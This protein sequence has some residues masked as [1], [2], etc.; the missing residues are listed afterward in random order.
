MVKIAINIFLSTLLLVESLVPRTE[1]LEIIQLPELFTHFKK[2]KQERPAMTILEF[3]S[4]HYNDARHYASDFKN[5]QKLPFSKNHHNH[6]IS[7]Q[8][9][10]QINTPYF[11]LE[12]TLLRLIDSVYYIEPTTSLHSNTVWQPP[13]VS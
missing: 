1:L 2:H 10:Q 6:V 4:L 5:H 8:V 3:L 13:R 7:F 9:V 11:A 12:Y